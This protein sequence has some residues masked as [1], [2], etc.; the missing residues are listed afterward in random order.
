[1]CVDAGVSG[2]LVFSMDRC[3]GWKLCAYLDGGELGVF[4]VQ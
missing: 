2:L 3:R 1:M 4:K